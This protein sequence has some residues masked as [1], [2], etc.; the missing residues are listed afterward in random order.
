MHTSE[1]AT[2]SIYSKWSDGDVL[3][4]LFTSCSSPDSRLRMKSWIESTTLTMSFSMAIITLSTVKS[5]RGGD[6]DTHSIN[7]RVLHIGSVVKRTN[8]RMEMGYVTTL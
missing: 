1:A 5:V 2:G 4:L 6:L 8:K 7:H 3:D